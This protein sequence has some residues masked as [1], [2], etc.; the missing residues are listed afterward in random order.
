MNKDACHFCLFIIANTNNKNWKKGFKFI[1]I[2]GMYYLFA[3]A[4]YVMVGN[5]FSVQN[6]MKTGLHN[7][8][9]TERLGKVIKMSYAKVN[10]DYFDFEAAHDQLCRWSSAVYKQWCDIKI[11]E[12]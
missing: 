10:W 3:L 12:E 6:R 8:L 5:V 9:C 7:R 1:H 2:S 11:S 4:L